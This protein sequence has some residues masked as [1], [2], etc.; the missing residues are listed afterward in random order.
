MQAS[1]PEAG[2]DAPVTSLI[3]PTYNPGPVLERT[4]LQIERFLGSASGNWEV[5]FVCDG[6]T[7]QTPDRLAELS[8]SLPDRVRVLSHA[9]NRGK[10]YALRRGLDEARGAWRIFTDVDLAYG[11]DDVLRLAETLWAGAEVAIASRFH[12]DSRLLVPPR[13]QG[14]AY[15]R[16]WQSRMFSTLVRLLLPLDQRDTQAGL[17]GLS[18]RAVQAVLPQ[19]GCNGFGFDCELLLACLRQ[20]LTV[21]EVPACVRYEDSSSTLSV[22]RTL[23][24]LRELWRLHRGWRQDH[25]CTPALLPETGRL[26]TA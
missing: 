3:L 1:Q 5:L 12:P 2:R 4:W 22:G 25:R 26:E 10:G 7:D 11:L 8:R 24:V 9:P 16:H 13:L 17:K 15:R 23:S 14:Y 20:G 21:T 19:L 6:C 18:A